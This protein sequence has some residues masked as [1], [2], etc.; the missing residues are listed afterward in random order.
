MDMPRLRMT[1]T[2]KPKMAVMA[3]KGPSVRL[4]KGMEVPQLIVPQMALEA[5]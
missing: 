2:G 1:V 4:R 5:C 3:L